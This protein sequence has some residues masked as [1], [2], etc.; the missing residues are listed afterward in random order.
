MNTQY[1]DLFAR[2]HDHCREQEW[3]G[4]DLHAPARYRKRYVY[5]ISMTAKRTFIEDR[6]SDTRR[7]RY[8]YPPQ[9]KSNFE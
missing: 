5:G 9:L 8:P 3:Y 6:W 7:L 1:T 2:I 4:P